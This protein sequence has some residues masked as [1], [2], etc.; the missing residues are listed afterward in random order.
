MNI[1]TIAILLFALGFVETARAADEPLATH[2][3]AWLDSPGGRLAFDLEFSSGG[4]GLQAV[5]INGGERINVSDVVINADR[6]TITIGHF[7]SSL[8]A[9]LSAGNRE[10]HGQWRKRR[11]LDA[12]TEMPFHAVVAKASRKALAPPDERAARI[13][14][15]RWRVKFSSSDDPAVGVF[16]VQRDGTATGTFLTPTG[17]YRYLSGRVEG[18]V[19]ELSCFDGAHAFL[20]RARLTDDDKLVGDFWSRD[21]WHETWEAVKDPTAALPDAFTQSTVNEQVPLASLAFPDL[22]GNVRSLADPA[23]AGKA[24]IIEIFGTWCPN[25]NDATQ[26]LVDLH[27][28]YADRGLSIVGLAFELTGDAKRDRRQVRKYIEHHEIPYPILIAGTSDKAKASERFP[29]ID[30]IRSYPTTLFLDADGSVIAIHTGFSGPATGEEYEKLQRDFE[31][32]IEQ[33]ITAEGA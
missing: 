26:Y 24:R 22:D 15:G 16:D 12:W 13:V 6:I 20:F 8:T 21:V 17:D 14:T 11:S 18:N 29:L 31:R 9:R 2:W 33:I 28:R 30:R 27:E 1:R 23:F 3:S 4:S 19:L 25:C 32:I 10:M 5:F 7:D